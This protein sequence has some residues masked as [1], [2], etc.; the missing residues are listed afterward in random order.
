MILDMERLVLSGLA[1]LAV[2]FVSIAVRLREDREFALLGSGLALL[3]L[4]VAPDVWAAPASAEGKALGSAWLVVLQDAQQIAACAFLWVALRFTHSLIGRPGWRSLRIHAAIL[5]ALSLGFYLDIL[6]PADLFLAKAPGGYAPTWAFD[7]VYSPYMLLL[8]GWNNVLIVRGWRVAQGVPRRTLGAFAFAYG[9]LLLGGSADFLAEWQ[10]PSLSFLPSAVTLASLSMGAIG[11]YLFSAKLIHLYQNLRET[12]LKIASIHGDLEAHRSLGDLGRSAAHISESIRDFVSEIKTDAESLRSHPATAARAESA[13][14][15][16]ARSRLETFTGAILEF[17]RSARLGERR[18][19]SPAAL[20]ADCLAEL[21]PEE[22]ALVRVSGKVVRPIAG[23]PALLR[24]ALE[25]LIR[26]ALQAGARRI[27]VRLVE[28]LGRLSVAVEDNGIGFPAEQLGRIAA[29]FFTTRKAG[30]AC[31]L[32][33]SIAQGIFRSHGGSL[34]YYPAP[35]PARAGLLANATLPQ[36]SGPETR[37]RDASGWILICDDAPRIERYLEVC[38]NV[39]IVPAV[40]GSVDPGAAGFAASL[41]I[42]D[43]AAGPVAGL[44]PRWKRFRLA[45]DFAEGDGG[46]VGKGPPWL[47]EETLLGWAAQRPQGVTPVIP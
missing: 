33:A 18:L 24:R 44:P 38:A 2:L 42:V 19:V 7:Y 25:E 20:A 30:G 13:R 23:D 35:L 17:S 32:G 27:E 46:D 8:F 3:C 6:S 36:I 21:P 31:G 22:R 34:A 15:E 4:V 45:G 9:L 29:P 14:I 41:A 11:T 16:N 40:R 39:G 37:R 28:G 10:Q 1:A 26:N 5:T 43:A 47:R 12:M